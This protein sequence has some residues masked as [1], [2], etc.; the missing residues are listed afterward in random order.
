MLVP[1]LF[2]VA[3]GNLFGEVHSIGEV[4]SSFDC[5]SGILQGKDNE[6][7]WWAVTIISEHSDGSVACQVHDDTGTVW[8]VVHRDNLGCGAADEVLDA[9]NQTHF[10]N[11]QVAE[12][13]QTEW[14]RYNPCNGKPV[15]VRVDADVKA[16]KTNIVLQP[17]DVF[18]VDGTGS[19]DE[20]IQ[21]L[22][23]ADGSGF[24]FDKIPGGCSMCFPVDGPQ[25]QWW[26]YTPFNGK[27]IRIRKHADITAE[28]TGK[29]LQP[30]HVF[31]VDETLD[32]DGVRFLRLADGSG[33]LFDQNSHGEL[34]TLVG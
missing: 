18:E 1:P 20:G 14:W 6:G 29:T 3:V 30:G 5:G 8:P 13:H 9:G 19:N 21:F 7:I 32:K 24:L 22:R 25:P 10:E 34:C 11:L 31:Q 26:R 33:W 12:E 15:A 2:F 27:Q 4:F 23:L 17:G 16:D 28:V